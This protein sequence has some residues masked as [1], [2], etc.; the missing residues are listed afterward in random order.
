MVAQTPD[1]HVTVSLGSSARCCLLA[2]GWKFNFRDVM[3][4]KQSMHV[5][6]M[7]CVNM[8]TASELKKRTTCADTS[9]HIG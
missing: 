6:F 3:P 1:D 2:L 5:Y 4:P 9:T 7:I 8:G